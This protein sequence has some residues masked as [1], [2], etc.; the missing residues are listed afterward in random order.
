MTQSDGEEKN[1]SVE[2]EQKSDSESDSAGPSTPI[3]ND[4]VPA[5]PHK[6][7]HK[8]PAKKQEG[9]TRSLLKKPSS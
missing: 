7:P 4:D 9:P 2:K 3:R 6:S 8:S 1:D 5:S